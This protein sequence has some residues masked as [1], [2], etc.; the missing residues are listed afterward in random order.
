MSIVPEGTHDWDKFIPPEELERLLESNGF[1]VDTLRGMLYNPFMGSW[2]WFE[3]TSINYAVH[4]LKNVRQEQTSDIDIE[5]EQDL[6][7][8]AEASI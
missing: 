8:A 5:K 1:V 4:A 6:S 3:D 7:K 2:S